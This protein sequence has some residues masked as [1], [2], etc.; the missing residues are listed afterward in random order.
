MT[1]DPKCPADDGADWG[2][3]ARYLKRNEAALVDLMARVDDLIVDGAVS[4]E[5]ESGDTRSPPAGGADIVERLR[6]GTVMA[7]VRWPGDNSPPVDEYETDALTAE[8]ADEIARLRAE[9]ERLTG[10]VDHWI[11]YART[12]ETHAARLEDRRADLA[13]RVAE[14]ERENEQL[15]TAYRNL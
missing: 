6:Q 2:E 3:A 5:P 9:V 13:A 14:L 12:T 4:H 10:Q 15:A 11:G 7:D 1:G 8:A